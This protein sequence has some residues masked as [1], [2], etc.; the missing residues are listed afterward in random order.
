[1]DKSIEVIVGDLQNAEHRQAMLAQ[2]D[3]YMQDPMAGHGKM[4]EILASEIIDG[5]LIQPNYLF[6]L[7]KLNGEYAGVANCFVNFST[8]KAKPLINIHDFS[9]SPAFRKKGIG[10]AMMAKIIGYA[11]E[12]GYAKVNLEVRHDNIGAQNLYKKVGFV[13]CEPPMYFWE[14]KV[15][16]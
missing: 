13:E 11:R 10:E 1:M 16:P 4:T 7:A 9:V 14:I 3:L 8:F 12:K 6:F 15:S 2:L 5:L